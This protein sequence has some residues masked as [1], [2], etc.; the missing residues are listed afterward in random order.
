MIITNRSGVSYVRKHG[1]TR[2]DNED[3]RGEVKKTVNWIRSNGTPWRTPLVLFQCCLMSSFARN[4]VHVYC[5]MFTGFI[6]GSNRRRWANNILCVGRFHPL[7][8][9]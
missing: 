6:T 2:F 9:Q 3:Q 8:I 1:Q 5:S 7:N 4:L